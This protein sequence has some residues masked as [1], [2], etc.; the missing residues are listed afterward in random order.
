MV[1]G[2]A[3]AFAAMSPS[4]WAAPK[5]QAAPPSGH[6]TSL[7]PIPARPSSR[8]TAPT[9]QQPAGSSSP[10]THVVV[11]AR[12]TAAIAVQRSP[13]RPPAVKQAPRT[14][15]SVAKPGAR[16]WMRR[17]AAAFSKFRPVPASGASQLLLWAGL[18]LALLVIGEAT[19]LKLAGARLGLAGPRQTAARGDLESFPISRVLPRR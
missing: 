19:F 16:T 6:V 9:L 4:A 5:P 11:T 2:C 8:T 12:Q 18:A 10:S 1:V 14:A 13:A 15:R 7:R 17:E 3:V